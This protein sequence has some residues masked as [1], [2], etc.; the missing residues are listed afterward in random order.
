MSSGSVVAAVEVGD[1]FSAMV[2]VAPV[3]RCVG[4]EKRGM[5]CAM[6]RRW[7]E[8]KVVQTRVE[9]PRHDEITAKM[10][11]LLQNSPQVP[12]RLWPSPASMKPYAKMH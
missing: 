11:L 3:C 9:A 2:R 12:L 10:M 4:E 6:I 7:G 5:L 8:R 1:W